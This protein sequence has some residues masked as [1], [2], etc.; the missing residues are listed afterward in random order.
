MQ[1]NSADVGRHKIQPGIHS[2]GSFQMFSVKEHRNRKSASTPSQYADYLVCCQ[3]NV[4]QGNG[5]E[6][7]PIIDGSDSHRLKVQHGVSIDSNAAAFA[8]DAD[9][10]ASKQRRQKAHPISVLD[11]NQFGIP[12]RLSHGQQGL[13]RVY[14]AAVINNLKR[15]GFR[16]KVKVNL[17]CLGT[18]GTLHKLAKYIGFIGKTEAQAFDQIS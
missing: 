10:P 12:A 14:A 17:R 6:A 5:G 8:D 13:D 4:V 11:S 9:M 2:G 16:T 15:L 18:P 1:I 3:I 7:I